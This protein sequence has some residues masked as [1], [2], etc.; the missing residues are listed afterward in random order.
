MK[1][2]YYIGDMGHI[3]SAEAEGHELSLKLRKMMG[4]YF[5]TD[6][7]AEAYIDYLLAKE[8]IK[9]DTKGFK[10]DWNNLEKICFYGLWDFEYEMPVRGMSFTQKETTIY[11]KTVE[12]LRE[13]FEKHPKE[14]KTYLTYKQQ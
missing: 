2:Y 7:E 5:E 13:S 9:E 8:V 1:T 11:F 12:D 14:W 3:L 4:N 6:L 10:P